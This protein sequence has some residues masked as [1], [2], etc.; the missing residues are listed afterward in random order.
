MAICEY[1]GGWFLDGNGVKSKF[2]SHYY[3]SQ[4]CYKESDSY[5]N[6]VATEKKYDDFVNSWIALSEQKNILGFVVRIPLCAIVSVILSGVFAILE[7]ILG[8]ALKYFGISSTFVF[9]ITG[10]FLNFTDSLLANGITLSIVFFLG[11]AVIQSIVLQFIGK[12]IM[13]ISQNT[14]FVLFAVATILWGFVF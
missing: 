4:K 8:A 7:L 14:F 11:F 3:C 13:W 12:R 6:D 1:C 5:I 2:G 9:N 10:G